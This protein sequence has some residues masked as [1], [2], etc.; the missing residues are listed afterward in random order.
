[1]KG[2][3]VSFAIVLGSLSTA[4]QDFAQAATQAMDLHSLPASVNCPV[5]LTAKRGIG[6][7]GTL[8]IYGG[9]RKQAGQEL[10]LRLTNSKATEIT[11]F[12]I[13]V[14]GFAGKGGTLYTAS[15]QAEKADPQEAKKTLNVHMTIGVNQE[16][17]T[18]LWLKGFTATSLI[19]VNSIAYA[20]GSTWHPTAGETCHFAPEGTLLISSVK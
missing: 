10:Q 7:G 8:A 5:G 18:S 2:F 9:Q 1:M 6:H 11:E 3:V 16:S 12:R 17:A 19:D 15:S 20:D 13:T 4:T 14:H